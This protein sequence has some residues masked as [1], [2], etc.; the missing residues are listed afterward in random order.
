MAEKYRVTASEIYRG[1]V[2]IATIVNGAVKCVRGQGRYS[3]QATKEYKR[4][5][6]S[7]PSSSHVATAI[8]DEKEV[9]SESAVDSSQSGS[10][11]L[12]V[13][14]KVWDT[15]KKSPT[16]DALE[17]ALDIYC[18]VYNDLPE[19]RRPIPPEPSRSPEMGNK[20]PAY[21]RWL[22][23]YAPDRYQSELS[24]VWRSKWEALVAA[25]DPFTQE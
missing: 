14:Y 19:G 6:D 24:D 3:Q 9:V 8:D 20:T 16:L 15:I 22:Q 18:G 4:W 5:L 7:H 13:L 25:G 17:K 21:V 12:S 10:I 2:L 1:S 23:E 11:A